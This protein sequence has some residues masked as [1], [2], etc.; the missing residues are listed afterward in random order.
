M[1][2]LERT[3][4]ACQPEIVYV[5][6]LR[7]VTLKDLNKAVEAG[8]LFALLDDL[9]RRYGVLFRI[10]HHYRK[11]QGF[12]VG[13]GSQEIGGSYVLGAWA[14]NSVW[15]EPVGRK[16]DQRKVEVQSKDGAPTPPFLLTMTSDGPMYAPTS[17]KLSVE[18][19]STAAKGDDELKEKIVDLIASLS[20]DT[21]QKLAKGDWGISKKQVAEAL[22]KSVRTVE[23]GLDLLLDEE[24]IHVKGHLSSKAKLYAIKEKKTA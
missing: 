3:I 20:P 17:M 16:L 23:R 4:A 11:S 14:E 6:V 21:T 2:R 22:S 18:E 10:I 5:D 9:R 15:F 24:R 7:K 12:R 13:R 1:R 8:W 19:I